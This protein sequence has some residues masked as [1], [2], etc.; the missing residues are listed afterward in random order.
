MSILE[1][2]Y[3]ITTEMPLDIPAF[4]VEGCLHARNVAL[5]LLLSIILLRF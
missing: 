3:T 5:L 2:E 1:I 4:I